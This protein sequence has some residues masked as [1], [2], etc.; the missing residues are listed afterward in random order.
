MFILWALVLWG[1]FYAGLLGYSAI[2][3]G[4]SVALTRILA[5]RDPMGGAVNLALAGLALVVWGLIGVAL[6]GRGRRQ[7]NEPGDRPRVPRSL[8]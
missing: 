1:T 7:G 4:P 2:T 5:S 8:E 6:V 3:K